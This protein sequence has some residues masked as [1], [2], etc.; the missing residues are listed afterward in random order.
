MARLQRSDAADRMSGSLFHTPHPCPQGRAGYRGGNGPPV[1]RG[2]H[3]RGNDTPLASPRQLS[4]PIVDH[5]GRTQGAADW[6]PVS[7]KCFRPPCTRHP[8]TP[9]RPRDWFE[10]TPRRFVRARRR[11]G[12]HMLRRPTTLRARAPKPQANLRASLTSRAISG[13]TSTSESTTLASACPRIRLPI[14][15]TPRKAMEMKISVSTT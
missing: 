12:L 5:K 14:G 8:L 4:R 9:C 6:R 10:F 3:S 11:M 2:Y 1:A 15:R 13:G 7:R